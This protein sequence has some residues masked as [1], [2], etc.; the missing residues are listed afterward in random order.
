MPGPAYPVGGTAGDGGRM[1]LKIDRAAPKTSPT[2]DWR[3]H[4]QCTSSTFHL[5][6]Y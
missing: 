1:T 5:F 6:Q 4:H 2:A 3:N